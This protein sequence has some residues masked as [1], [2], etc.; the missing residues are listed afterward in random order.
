MER[1]FGAGEALED[2][3]FVERSGDYWIIPSEMDLHEDYI[4]AG[5]RAIRDT[6]IG[7]KP[8]TYFLQIL[9]EKIT[10]NRF[11][12]NRKLFEKIV[13]NRDTIENKKLPE[14]LENG[15]VAL[16]FRGSIIGCGLKRNSGLVT[17]IPKGRSKILE[18]II[19]DER[20]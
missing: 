3:R 6:G 7:L 2:Y 9:D 5:L 8:T 12:L 10:R 13:I 14:E 17:Q 15:Y 1:R 16:E 11:M 19:R 18:D 4:T 20:I